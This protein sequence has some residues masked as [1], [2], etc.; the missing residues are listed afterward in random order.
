M[1][2]AVVGVDVGGTNTVIG[3]FS[4]ELSC[5]DM[6]NVPTLKPNFSEKTNNPEAFFDMLASEILSLS[7]RTGYKDKI[8]CVG[9]GVP[10]KVNPGTGIAIS[11]VNLGYEKVPFAA[12]MSNRLS[13]PVYIDNDVRNYTRGEAL[14]GSGKGYK[15]LICLTLGTG[16]A[17]GIMVDGTMVTGHDFFAGE[18]GHDSVQGEEFLCNCGKLGCLETIASATGI[19]R[20]AAE[21]IRAGRK[22]ILKSIKG[23]KITSRDVYLASLQ[24]DR[25]A[26]EIFGFVGKTLAN[27]LV[28]V[29]FLLNPQAIVIGGGAAAA[30]KF[31]LDPIEEVFK[32]QYSNDHLPIICTGS[33]GDSAG[34]IGS[35]HLALNE[36]QK[37]ILVKERMFL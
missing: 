24:G 22:T 21:A 17:A 28:T 4:S 20:L 35:A 33:L 6:V 34:L 19:G 37:S 1:D 27:K 7:E 26:L 30:G 13:V 29:A 5:L 23:G 31:L 14:A 11:A 2:W 16:M 12:E 8:R 25:V 3:I 9:I 10:G 32:Q 15:N 18:I 36:Y